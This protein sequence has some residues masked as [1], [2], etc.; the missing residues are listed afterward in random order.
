MRGVSVQFNDDIRET[1]SAM[2]P[3]IKF[4]EFSLNRT[5]SM[6]VINHGLAPYFQIDALGNYEIHVYSFDESLNDST[7][8]SEMDLY[9]RYWDDRDKLVK[10]RY[11]G[12]SFLGH[13][14]PDDLLEHFTKLTK[15]LKSENLYQISVDGPNVN[16]KFYENFSRKF[17]DEICH[18]LI[19]IG[20][21]SLQIIHGAFG[22]GTEQSEWQLKKFLKGAFTVFHN[23][24]ACRE[25]YE[26]VSV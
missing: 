20:S 4:K 5:K 23:S 21:W 25:D 24:P 26:S 10:I 19:D 16:K 11:Y 18:K 22:A 15:K 14:K 2:F 13:C 3:D 6:Y 8:T 17:G 12:S 1:I 7:Q 9:V